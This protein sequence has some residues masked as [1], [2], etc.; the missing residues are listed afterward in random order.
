MQDSESLIGQSISHYRIVEKLGGGGMGVVYKAEDTT[1]H[2]FVA[3]KFLPDDM[4]RDPQALGRFRR[5]AQAASA[6]NHPN[7]CTIYEIGEEGGRAFIV[8]E[9]LDGTTLKHRIGGRPI[10]LEALVDLA[11]QVADGLDAAHSE[12][13][14]HRD[15]KPANVF[16]TKRGHAKILDFGLAKMAPAGRVAQGIGA[17]SMPTAVADELLTSPGATVGT[18]AYMSP[19]Q[20][21]GK[22]L[23]ARTDLFSFGVVLYEMAT[24]ALPF[25]GDTSGVITDAIL[26]QAP[27]APV[28][29]NPE[30]P[31]K[32]EEII[33]RAIEKDRDLRYQHASDLR[34]ELKRLKRDT[35]S[36][37]IHSSASGAVQEIT[38]ER[39]VAQSAAAEGP[40]SRAR[41]YLVLAA[42]L[43]LLVA[44]IAAFHFWPRS[45]APTG[46][47]SITQLSQWN[48]PMDDA[49]LSPDGRAVAFD[50]PVGGIG[51]VFLMLTSGSEPLQLT[52]DEGDKYVVSFSPDGKQVYFGKKLGHA[53][54]WG[55]QALGG[56]PQRVAA[57]SYLIPSADGNSIFYV[58]P[59]KP[60][61][62]RA[63]K[64]GLNEETVLDTQVTKRRY[65]PIQAYPGG[66]QIF[67]A[68]APVAGGEHANFRF[69]DIDLT[70]HRAIDLGEVPQANR[71]A[72]WAEPGKSI[73]LS[74]TVNG[75]T[76]IWKYNLD[77]R[78][79]TQITF[80]TGPDF[81]PMPDPGGKGIYYVNGKSTGV[82][83]VYNVKSKGLTDIEG[84][85]A[86]QPAISP[87]KKRVMYVTQPYAAISQVWVSDIDG[88]NKV[89]IFSGTGVGT[90]SWAQDG[91]H[92]TFLSSEAS[93]SPRVYVAAADGSSVV[94]LP[95]FDATPVSA[96]WSE[97]QKSVYVSGQAS[98]ERTFDIW[99]WQ[100]GSSSVERFVD[101]CG[102]A[103]DA[104]PS[105]RYLIGN[106]LGGEGTGIYEISVPEGKCTLLAP[107]IV[108]FGA[109]FERDGKSFLYA[110]AT[111][112]EVTIYRQHWKDGKLIGTPEAALKVPFVF[113]V[114]YGGN[115]Y[116][117]SRDLSTIVYARPG[118][119]ADLYLL[120]QK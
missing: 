59:D 70:A 62:F 100:V 43:V 27:V 77:D 80:G 119:H 8:M 98:G 64:S 56:T 116:D 21:R 66:K 88:G 1:L 51:Q 25:R 120:N 78:S 31:P 41:E 68:D 33:N 108:T 76:N 17:S 74:R 115:A 95:Q 79:L 9:F 19:E 18:V 39:H 23:D 11:T 30:I 4:A 29:L 114:T 46:A 118:G 34:S 113:P 87:D 105:G 69:C 49:T 55:V 102:F 93:N 106:I 63:D 82:L 90:A 60:G 71:D 75:L 97:D 81:S 61:V 107:G 14:V 24:G 7:I 44:G 101:K 111:R 6:L 73:Y 91:A 26:H 54:I 50:S 22:E 42:L 40:R 53:E 110:V 35:D 52:S 5:E 48:K 20:V 104:D 84:E 2:R 103:A 96:I 85:D 72:V 65:I 92:L 28:R 58:K 3:L 112:G 99:K 10:E 12:G 45:G 13:V 86:S 37:R 89:K 16:V 38:G 57:A 83:S 67:A 32:L 109:Y 94:G 36:S 15:I 117:F 47:P